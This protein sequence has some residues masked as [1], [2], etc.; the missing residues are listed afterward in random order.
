MLQSLILID[1]LSS[2]CWEKKEKKIEKVKKRERERERERERNGQGLFS[3]GQRLN[4]PCW[5]CWARFL[6]LFSTIKGSF[7]GQSLNFICI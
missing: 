5:L 1:S 2:L 3:Q 6:Q 7:K 4:M